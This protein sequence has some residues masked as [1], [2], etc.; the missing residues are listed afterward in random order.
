MLFGRGIAGGGARLGDDLVG[1][2]IH[3]P[4]VIVVAVGAH[5]EDRTVD[6]ALQQFESGAGSALMFATLP[7]C[8]LS[9]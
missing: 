7:T 6:V 1:I 4:V 8:S 5:D 2:E 9:R 3:L